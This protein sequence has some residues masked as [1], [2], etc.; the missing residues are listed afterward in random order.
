MFWEVQK[1]NLFKNRI[2]EQDE[3]T[4]ILMIY[5]NIYQSIIMIFHLEMRKEH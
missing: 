3:K 4:L 2:L 1:K 5:I